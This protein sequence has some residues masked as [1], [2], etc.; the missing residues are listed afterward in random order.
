LWPQG[1]AQPFT[2][3]TLFA[4]FEWFSLL[5]G[6]GAFIAL[7]RYRIGIIPVIGICGLVGLGYV[8]LKPVISA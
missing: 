4:G 6:A 1:L 5:I 3:R 8:L 7:F 2:A